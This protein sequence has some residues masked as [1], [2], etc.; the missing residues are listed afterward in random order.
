MESNINKK[1]IDE[2]FYKM[3]KDLPIL[4][5]E[6]LITSSGGEYSETVFEMRK[7]EIKKIVD[8]EIESTSNYFNSMKNN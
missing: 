2:S 1:M 5:H 3:T 7:N 6:I 8:A 4:I